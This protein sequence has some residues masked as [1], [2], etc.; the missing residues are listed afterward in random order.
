M[1]DTVIS[2]DKL[3][4]RYNKNALPALDKLT[5]SIN[6]GEVYGFLG[7]N[8]AG[9]STTIRILM[10]FIQPSRGTAR[11][12]G[13]DVVADSVRLKKS[14]GYLAG[15]VALYDKMTG[16]DFLAY[17]AA[18]QP[19]RHRGRAGELAKRLQANLDKPIRDLSKG[20]RQKIGLIQAFMHEPEVLIL[21]EPTSGLDP[22]MQEEFFALVRESSASGATLFISSHNLSE[23]QKMC[24]RVGFIREGKLVGEQNI[25]EAVADAA[26]SFDI[27]FDGKVPI[28]ELK[29][30][31]GASLSAGT[32][33]GITVHMR[34]ELAPLFR[35]LARHK[36]TSINQ[37][38][39]D[40][41]NE[42]LKFYGD[43]G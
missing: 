8:G 43:R 31:P 16:R 15:E 17:M 42:F 4:K 26:R 21:D 10:N 23:V 29:D 5:L 22:L 24:D 37:R 18:L 19:T 30:I 1:P 41:E 25:A 6:R 20:N 38:E 13:Q 7:P 9:K 11:I 33:N 32:R 39:L 40:L 36:V 14:I 28:G 2:L 12:L 35:V 3:T 27:N 34:G